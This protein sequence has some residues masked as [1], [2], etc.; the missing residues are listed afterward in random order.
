MDT[1][2]KKNYLG[3]RYLLLFDKG[4]A[5]CIVRKKGEERRDG[6]INAE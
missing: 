2:T 6:I 4:S 5:A 3:R 1:I